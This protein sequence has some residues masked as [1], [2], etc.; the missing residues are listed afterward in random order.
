MTKT[1]LRLPGGFLNER[2]CCITR[3][4]TLALSLVI[5]SNIASTSGP[6]CSSHYCVG[7][8]MKEGVVQ[9]TH[10]DTAILRCLIYFALFLVISQHNF[11]RTTHEGVELDILN[12]L[13]NVAFLES[14]TMCYEYGL[15]ERIRA[16]INS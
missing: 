4:K 6:P 15:H 14:W 16:S 2:G 10:I 11:L 7:F 12:G 9:N 1:C 8:I 13:S 3:S 5:P